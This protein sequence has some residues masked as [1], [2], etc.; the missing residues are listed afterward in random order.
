MPTVPYDDGVASVAPEAS[1][2]NDYLSSSA[3]TPA[4]FGGQ[5]AE[6]AQKLGQGAVT[7][8]QFFNRVAADSAAND[9]QDFSTKLLHGDPN[10]MVTGPDGQQTPDTGYLGLRGRAALDQRP[11]VERALD[12]KI[13]ELRGNL[14]SPDQQL[15][16]DNFTRRYR[17]MTVERIGSHADGQATTW[18]TG[19]NTTTAKLAMDHISNNFDNPNEV[20]AGYHDLV[21]AYVKQ[22]QLSGAQPG[23]PQYSEALSAARRDGLQAQLNAMAVKD[24]SRAM[25]ILEKNRDI[26][27][28]KYD[29]M[30]RT[31]R[32]RANQQQGDDIAMQTLRESY[33][34]NPS[35]ATQAAVLTSAG[36]PYGISG[37]YLQRVHQLE[38]PSNDPRENSAHAQGPFQFIPGTAAKYGLTDRNNFQQSAAAAAHLA[39]DNRDALTHS[40][41][42]PPTDA[43]LYLAHQQGAQGAALLLAHPNVRA[44]DL[45]GDA[46]IR[47]NGGDPNAPASAFTSLWTAKFNGAPTVATQSRKA[48]GYQTI[49]AM[50]GISEE[51]RQHALTRFNQQ[52][53]ADQIAQEQD[54]KARKL[55]ADQAQSDLVSKII[56][57]SNPGIIAEI[58]NNPAL[59]G[60]QKENL[61]DFATNHGGIE[62]PLSYGP[63]YTQTMNRIM[64]PADDPAKITSVE[65]VIR[66]RNQGQLTRKG[67]ADLIQTMALIRKQPDQAGVATAKASILKYYQNQYGQSQSD[68]GG[69][70]KPFKNQKGL[71]KFDRE[72]V[73]AFEAS[74]S[75]WVGQ[76]KDPFEFLRDTKSLDALANRIYPP[77]QR[78][79]DT[80]QGGDNAG[81]PPPAP[82]GIEPSNW[83]KLMGSP[84]KGQVDGH[85]IT[86]ADWAKPL[87]WLRNNPT[88]ENKAKFDKTFAPSG[89]TADYVLK[90]LPPA[91]F[92]DVTGAPAPPAD[93]HASE[94]PPPTKPL[95]ER[96]PQ[97]LLPPSL[98]SG[99]HKEQPKP[100]PPAPNP[101][102]QTGPVETLGIRG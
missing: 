45:V 101:L 34:N 74:Y 58:A 20:A 94:P 42:R 41:G 77:D 38:N 44:G 49:L 22:A 64:A 72:F 33:Q 79:R 27:G 8:A 37:S 56:T 16:F 30:A 68:L 14:S 24:P 66:L 54:E 89:Y 65:D 86:A 4:A 99:A 17:S 87:I 102:L 90:Q 12:D 47:Q 80:L 31:F 10:K 81:K 39:A 48:A 83:D 78:A 97:T 73:P 26:A 92:N 51:V 2:P 76:N 18:Y 25:A 70:L 13:K 59:S 35:G 69:F 9:F 60:P 75:K 50:S 40:L 1:T 7:S 36:A 53:Q 71:D 52:V 63:G 15:E 84:P 5:L 61:Y 57:G 19:V 100:A 62:D 91:P 88:P 32:A 55:A 11:A 82:E 28:V 43:E 85:A 6:G 3:A 98:R 93:A 67:A 23:D 95:L 96:I 21:S 29:D 46:A